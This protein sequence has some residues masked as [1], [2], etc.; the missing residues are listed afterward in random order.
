MGVLLLG[1]PITYVFIGLNNI[2][3]ATG[4]PK[5]AM[6]SALFTVGANIIIAP[7]FIFVLKWG[8]KGAALATIISQTCGMIWVLHHFL[9]KNSFIHLCA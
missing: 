6:I 1:T 3:R 8:I 4:Y 9:D 5:K 2:M 7:I